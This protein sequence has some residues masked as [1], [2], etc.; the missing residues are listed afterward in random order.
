MD[1]NEIEAEYFEFEEKDASR[2]AEILQILN[3]MLMDL[4]LGKVESRTGPKA[5]IMIKAQEF[6]RAFNLLQNR[7]SLHNVQDLVSFR[8]IRNENNQPKRTEY[9]IEFGSNGQAN[10]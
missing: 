10:S 2:F 9:K 8:L 7:L 6:E 5:R 4:K 1:C 3:N